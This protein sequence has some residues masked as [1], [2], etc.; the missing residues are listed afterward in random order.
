MVLAEAATLAAAGILLGVAGAAATT[1]LMA[2]ML[3]GITP[4]D[5]STFASIAGILLLVALA[6]SYVPAWRATRVDPMATLRS[7]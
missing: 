7:E 5:P 1:R 2:A 6:G 4:T 3:F